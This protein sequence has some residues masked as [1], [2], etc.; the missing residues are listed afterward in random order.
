MCICLF[1]P[2]RQARLVEF[3]GV[4]E[5]TRQLGLGLLVVAAV[6]H[7]GVLATCV[8]AGV[9]FRDGQVRLP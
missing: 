8:E 2:Q 7:A 6:V 9:V 5:G 3:S 4:A 1:P